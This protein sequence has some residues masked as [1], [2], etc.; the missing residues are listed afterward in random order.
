[1]PFKANVCVEEY[2]SSSRWIEESLQ[3]SR[4]CSEKVLHAS[5][6]WQIHIHLTHISTSFDIQTAAVKMLC[7]VFDRLLFWHVQLGKPGSRFVY[8]CVC[9]NP[10]SWM[11]NLVVKFTSLNVFIINFNEMLSIR[12]TAVNLLIV[13]QLVSSHESYQP[14]TL[15]FTVTS[16]NFFPPGFMRM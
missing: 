9:F 4:V 6:S 14:C 15:S 3:L 12:V 11:T 16:Y 10:Y 8:I 1:M 2:Y 7:C 5:L 13:H